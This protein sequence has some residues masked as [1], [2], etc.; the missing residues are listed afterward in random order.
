MTMRGEGDVRVRLFIDFVRSRAVHFI[1][2]I[3]D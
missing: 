2:F 3:E 1:E